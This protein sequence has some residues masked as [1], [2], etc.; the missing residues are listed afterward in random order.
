MLGNWGT[1]QGVWGWRGKVG[2]GGRKR[3][4][5]VFVE[6]GQQEE[7]EGGISKEVLETQTL[8]LAD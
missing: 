5:D 4:W 1:T 7:R 8:P 2:V 6:E 3:S